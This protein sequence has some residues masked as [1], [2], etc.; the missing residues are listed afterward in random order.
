MEVCPTPKPK[1]FEISQCS[2]LERDAFSTG[3]VDKNQP[4]RQ[5]KVMLMTISHF[6][7]GGAQAL[8]ESIPCPNHMAS[9]GR[10]EWA[11]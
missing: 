4:G 2:L 5:M 11:A 1:L 3:Q 6:P 10:L 9:P 8:S 7:N